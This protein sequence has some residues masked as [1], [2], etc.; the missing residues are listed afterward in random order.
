MM[1]IEYGE[2]LCDDLDGMKVPIDRVFHWVVEDRPLAYRDAL[3]EALLH[4]RID[5]QQE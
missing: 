3:A 5:Q 4:H 2:R 1:S